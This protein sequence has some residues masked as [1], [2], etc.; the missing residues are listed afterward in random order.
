MN[1]LC[2]VLVDLAVTDPKAFH[3]NI[4]AS[5]YYSPKRRGNEIYV[6]YGT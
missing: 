4:P 3:N 6:I 1:V 5:K 2:G